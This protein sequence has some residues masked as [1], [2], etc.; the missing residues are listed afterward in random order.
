MPNAQ[1]V[2]RAKQLSPLLIVGV[3]FIK[4]TFEEEIY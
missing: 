3:G 4:P 2:C 1:G